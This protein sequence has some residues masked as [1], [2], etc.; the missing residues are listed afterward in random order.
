MAVEFMAEGQLQIVAFTTTLPFIQTST[1]EAA[2]EYTATEQLQIP[3][4]M[5]ILLVETAAGFGW[6]IVAQ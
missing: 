3:Q 4:Y 2:V 6:M 1:M 5:T